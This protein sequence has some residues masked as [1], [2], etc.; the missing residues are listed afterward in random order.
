MEEYLPNCLALGISEGE[1][2]DM[3]ITKIRPYLKAEEIRTER[4]NYEL[5]LQGAYIYEAFSVVL[6]NAFA[7]KGS[8]KIEYSKEPYP[9]TKRQIEA[10]ERRKQEL[11]KAQFAQF[12]QGLK[13]KGI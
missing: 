4:K 13:D 9:V 6:G 12:A 1:F 8:K 2:W 3:N 11:W 7:K 5:W 10:H